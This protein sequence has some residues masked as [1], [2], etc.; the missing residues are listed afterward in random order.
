MRPEKKYALI[1]RKLGHSFSKLYFSDKFRE[2]DLP[3]SYLNL[4]FASD[5]D[6][7][8]EEFLKYTGLNVTIPY[9]ESVL[10]LMDELSEVANSIQAVN[11]IQVS[12]GR[13]IGHNTDAYG[14]QEA[15]KP[16]LK[17]HHRK[18]LV[19]GSGGASKAVTYVL[20]K[21]GLDYLVVSR[22]PQNGQIGY[23]DLNDK[24]LEF[25]PFIINTSPLGMFPDVD[26]CPEIP[27]EFLSAKNF[28]FDLTYNPEESLFLKKGKAKGA[29]ILNGRSML[30]FQAE[31]SWEIWNSSID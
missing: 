1:G 29:Q 7:M 9:K 10:P 6:L 19:L 2:E 21:L 18:A 14:F 16:F 8:R 26:T 13:L 12:S 30:E 24:A 5:R 4:E 3:H 20:D 25:F 28:L 23:G 15:L 22:S 31:K 17:S 27:Y 11:C